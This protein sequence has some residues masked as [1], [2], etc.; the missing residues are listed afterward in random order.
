M[1]NKI[2]TVFVL[3]YNRSEY[4]RITVSSILNQTYSN[5]NL[6]ILDNCSTD[7]TEK[8]VNGFADPR[9][10][11]IKH[12]ENIGGIRNIIYALNNCDTEYCVVFH[13]DD[14]MLPDFLKKEL[15]ILDNN[16]DVNIVSC[17]A[18]LIDDKGNNIGAIFP[19][20]KNNG[21]TVW[22]TDLIN[23]YISNSKTL[24]FPTIM[25][26]M[27][28]IR[29]NN[30]SPYEEA[31]PGCDVVFY[32]EILSYG[33][34]ACELSEC[35]IKYRIHKGQDTKAVNLF[36]QLKMFTFMKEHKY[37][38]AVL[39]TEKRYMPRVY[40]RNVNRIIRELIKQNI[41]KEKAFLVLKEYN[42]CW[43]HSWFDEC[44]SSIKIH[45]TSLLP[46]PL[47]RFVIRLR[48]FK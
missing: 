6:V 11:Y 46:L 8:V 12:K 40:K 37:F 22:Q 43:N 48:G 28:P 23:N 45:I 41:N 32:N 13:D 39:E 36:N 30:I 38:A 26:R 24:V 35:L 47:I 2:L 9:I 44:F 29:N 21:F 14:V 25:Y 5:F 19:P 31:G 27:K 1:S 17:N 18:F 10:H 3:T 7:D 16:S 15:D 20:K 4:L 33:G 34:K 42:N